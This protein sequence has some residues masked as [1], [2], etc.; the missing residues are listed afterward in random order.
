MS[1]SSFISSFCE[2]SIELFPALV[3]GLLVS[4]IVNECVSNKWVENH[5]GGR[6]IKG[7]LLSTLVGAM[8]PVC[9]WGSLPIAVSFRKKGAS[10]G[11]IFALLIATPATSINAVV[12]MWRFMGFVFACYVFFSVI[13]MGLVSGLIANAV[14]SRKIHGGFSG[15]HAHSCECA[16]G[17]ESNKSFLIRVKAVLRYAFIDMPREIGVEILIGIALAAFVA[18]CDPVGIAVQK[19]LTQGYD[20]LFAAGFGLSVYMCATMSIP[21]VHAFIGQGL[22]V[23][24]GLTLLII[25]PIAS[26]GTI[27]VL[28]K[29]FGL[30]VLLLFL[31]LVCSLAVVAGLIF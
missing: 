7:V 27:L 11:A 20:Y 21:L 16:C 23:G 19:Y 24:A 26:Y 8:V 18:S 9:C 6:G 22:R 25:G 29:E 30:K 3:I 13:V 10:L 12:V 5:L 1:I 2:Y 15:G 31:T 4:G 28:R 14:S 17:G